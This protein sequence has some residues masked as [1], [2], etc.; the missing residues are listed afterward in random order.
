MHIF[1]PAVMSDSVDR[2][3]PYT[4][5]PALRRRYSLQG[6]H[7]TTLLKIRFPAGWTE[8][9]RSHTDTSGP[10]FPC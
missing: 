4:V 9:K 6:V 10:D 8:A 7:D 2:V 1:M 3:R 5:R